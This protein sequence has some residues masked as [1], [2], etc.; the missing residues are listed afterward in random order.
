MSGETYRF[1]PTAEALNA[2]FRRYEAE[3]QRT[4][5]ATALADAPS[6]AEASLPPLPSCSA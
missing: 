3:R 5:I 1:V 2:F 6:T 4:G